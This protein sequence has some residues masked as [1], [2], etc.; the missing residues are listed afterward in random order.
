MF[1]SKLSL[2]YHITQRKRENPGRENAVQV[3]SQHAEIQKDIETMWHPVR[4]PH[5]HHQALGLIMGRKE[6]AQSW[7]RKDWQ[8]GFVCPKFTF[9][10]TDQ[11]VPSSHFRHTIN[12]LMQFSLGGA[13]H[14]HKHEVFYFFLLE[15]YV[16]LEKARLKPLSL[17]NCSS[18]GFL[19]E[20]CLQAQG[21]LKT[22]G[23]VYIWRL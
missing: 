12:L 20:K 2:V 10:I 7:I 16:K 11:N 21:N 19:I 9:S 17:F 6:D 1:N 8:Q 14:K 15:G 5:G 22:A 18:Y 3:R 4:W 23:I 13:K